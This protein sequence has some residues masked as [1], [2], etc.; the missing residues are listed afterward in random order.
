[1]SD[2]VCHIGVVLVLLLCHSGREFEKV[3]SHL[4][5]L[6]LNAAPKHDWHALSSSDAACSHTVGGP[7]AL[8]LSSVVRCQRVKVTAA[9]NKAACFLQSDK[10]LMFVAV[11]ANSLCSLLP[12]AGIRSWMSSALQSFAALD[13]TAEAV[14]WRDSARRR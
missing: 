12:C 11:A 14:T 8:Q 6:Q 5:S 13:D 1:M 9:F 4:I 2:D 7:A 3:P 10:L